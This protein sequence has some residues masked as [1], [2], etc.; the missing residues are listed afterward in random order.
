MVEQNRYRAMGSSGNA[1]A[2]PAKNIQKAGNGIP[3]ACLDLD[4]CLPSFLS[5]FFLSSSVQ[6]VSVLADGLE[7]QACSISPFSNPISY[8]NN[9][10]SETWR[11]MFTSVFTGEVFTIARTWESPSCPLMN[12]WICKMWF[13]QTAEYCLILEKMEIGTHAPTKI[14]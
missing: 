14:L 2:L 1:E 5:W 10:E 4:S 3:I 6:C 11:N 7:G 12:R 13:I 8:C 9:L